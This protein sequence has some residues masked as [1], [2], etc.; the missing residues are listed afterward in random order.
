MKI[1]GRRGARVA[2]GWHLPGVPTDQSSRRTAGTNRTLTGLPAVSPFLGTPLLE[3]AARTAPSPA[4]ALMQRLILG[5]QLLHET[6]Q[7]LL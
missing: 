5:L 7:W 4:Q 2:R 6:D 1:A 3:S